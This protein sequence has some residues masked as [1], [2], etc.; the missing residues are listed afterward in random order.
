MFNLKIIFTFTKSD[1]KSR[2]SK[3]KGNFNFSGFKA[4]ILDSISL[5]FI[6][7]MKPSVVTETTYLPIIEILC[8]HS[9]LNLL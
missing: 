2:Y 8:K 5:S 6:S 7:E 9:M 1:L 4:K 3:N